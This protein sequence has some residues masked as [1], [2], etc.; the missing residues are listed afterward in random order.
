MSELLERPASCALPPGQ[1]SGSSLLGRGQGARERSREL[2]DQFIAQR[3]RFRAEL[4]QQFLSAYENKVRQGSPRHEKLAALELLSALTDL[5][6]VLHQHI[7][8]TVSEC[9]ARK[10]S[11]AQI[12]RA[13]AITKQA[14]HHRFTSIGGDR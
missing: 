11:W 4:A 3:E 2:A 6:S 9:R 1:V 7:F 13:L 5:E 14:A 12:G 8:G 10:A